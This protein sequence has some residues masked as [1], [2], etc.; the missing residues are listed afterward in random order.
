[1]AVGVFDAAGRDDRVI[2]EEEE[3]DEPKVVAAV[4]AE[5]RAGC[6]VVVVFILELR[7]APEA[8]EDLDVDDDVGVVDSK[9]TPPRFGSS[10]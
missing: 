4:K 9:S 10:T 5:E 3:A 1:M 8:I 6:L 7:V 2:E